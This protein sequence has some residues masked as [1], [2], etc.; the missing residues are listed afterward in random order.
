MKHIKLFLKYSWVV[1]TLSYCA[2]PAIL[3][4][5]ENNPVESHKDIVNKVKFSHD[6]KLLASGGHDSDIILWNG[7]DG[8]FIRL[9]N[10]KYDK[11]FDIVFIESSREIITANY[12]GTLIAWDEKT[13]IRKKESLYNNVITA[14]DFNVQ[15]GFFIVS[16]WETALDVLKINDHSLIE[17]CKSGD[18]KIHSVKYSEKTKSIYA[19]TA[20]GNLMRWSLQHCSEGENFN[21]NIHTSAA[22]SLDI[23]DELNILVTSSL[24]GSVKIFELGTLKE[25][26][27]L[28]DHN[29]P[30]NAVKIIPQFFKIA[31]GA[32]DGKMIVWD[33]KTGNKII[34]TA[35]VDSINSIDASPNGKLIATGSSDRTVKVWSLKKI[36]A[37]EK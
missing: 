11:I 24:D 26:G 28:K 29:S 6:G 31:S 33:M 3:I 36:L 21:K 7:S 27:V 1:F 8:K 22:T 17:K 20:G 16:S 25:T 4:N 37:G 18:Y 30:V 2:K 35:H 19:V 23:S 15:G 10:G 12:E 13:G 5:S 34:L 14:M 9:L 32:K